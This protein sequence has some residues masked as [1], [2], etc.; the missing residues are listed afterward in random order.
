MAKQMGHHPLKGTLDDLTFYYHPDDGYLVRKKSSMTKEKL[1]ANPAYNYFVDCGKEFTEATYAGHLLRKSLRR[2]LFPLADGK[3][4]S[5]MIRALL[6][7]IQS[8]TGNIGGER[9]PG[10]GNLLT[11]LGFE[12]NS[13]QAL[14]DQFKGDYFTTRNKATNELYI[15]IPAFPV[16]G[17]IVA[18]EYASHFQFVAGRALINFDEGR[19]TSRVGETISLPLDQP[20]TENL[21][22]ILPV[23]PLEG[24]IDV[25]VFGIKFSGKLENIP[26]NAISQRKRKRLKKIW[27]GPDGI[28]PYTGALRIIRI[29]NVENSAAEKTA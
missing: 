17:K 20:F 14:E 4:S 9:K 25:L 13:K 1:L 26:R 10:K 29:N 22:F 28:T 3:L 7:I 18:P 24:G 15:S 21:H 23:E 2:I 6:E 5:R 11:L 12:F 19:Y 16:A 27:T 8:D